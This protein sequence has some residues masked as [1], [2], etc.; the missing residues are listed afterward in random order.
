MHPLLAAR[1]RGPGQQVHECSALVRW[2]GLCTPAP[3]RQELQ[4]L[5]RAR[6][7]AAL[8]PRCVRLP[9]QRCGSSCWWA[10]CGSGR[11]N[12]PPWPPAQASFSQCQPLI[13]VHRWE[14]WGTARRAQPPTT[15]Q[16]RHAEGRKRHP[17]SATAARAA[18][19]NAGTRLK[20]TCHAYG[21]R[22]SWLRACVYLTR[23]S[24]SITHRSPFSVALNPR[25]L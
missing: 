7:R 2:A 13:W 12:D 16:R 14:G 15:H 17:S 19:C 11:R 18:G 10:G 20:I 21:E 22:F 25:N 3:G 5:V 4:R 24:L 9:R 6:P 8:W 1:L 23:K